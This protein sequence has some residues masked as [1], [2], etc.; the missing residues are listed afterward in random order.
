MIT[1]M[2]ISRSLGNYKGSSTT[3]IISNESVFIIS[4]QGVFDLHR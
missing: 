1:H 4:I 2:I 3:D